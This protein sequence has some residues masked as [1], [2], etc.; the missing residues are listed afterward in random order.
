MLIILA[1]RRQV[2]QRKSAHALR[3]NGKNRILCSKAILRPKVYLALST[4][5]SEMLSSKEID[6]SSTGMQ[7]KSKP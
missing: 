6:F 3:S 5:R 2:R 4:I 7:G 1:P